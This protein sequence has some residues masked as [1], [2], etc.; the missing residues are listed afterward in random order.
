MSHHEAS[1]GQATIVLV[2]DPSRRLFTG[3]VPA[4]H[5]FVFVVLVFM[6]EVRFYVFL[7]I[8]SGTNGESS[9]AVALGEGWVSLEQDATSTQRYAHCLVHN[10]HL[11]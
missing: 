5:V 8:F 2:S 4:S 11:R 10:Q 3:C 1:E 9:R 7:L 6:Y